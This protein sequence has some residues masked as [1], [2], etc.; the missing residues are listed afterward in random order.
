MA[1]GVEPAPAVIGFGK[2]HPK[3]GAA[4]QAVSA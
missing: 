3:A 4:W 2:Q 1:L